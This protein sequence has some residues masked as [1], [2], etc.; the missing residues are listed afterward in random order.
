ELI[1]LALAIDYSLLVVYRF[2]EELEHN[3]G[4]DEAVV[5]TMT[6]AGRSVVF[7]GAT[8]A[9]GL[10]LLVFI[11]VPFVRSLG[12]GGLL[13]PI[14]SV[15]AATTLLPAL[16]SIYGRA[17]SVRFRITRRHR[18][19]GFWHRLAGSSRAD[20]TRSSSSSV[21]TSTG[22]EP[23]SSSSN[24]SARRSS[25]GPGSRAV[26][27]SSSVGERPRA[28]TSFSAPT[29]RSPGSS[30]RCSRSRTRSSCE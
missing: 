25:R 11:P 17:G 4:V 15:A 23:H 22:S 19:S 18:R 7:S 16:L 14:V 29:V 5:R 8:V 26:R 10:A 6:T 20:A 13:I 12:I 24:V 1:G 30:S 21:G 27:A 2:R 9:L 3:D 28:S